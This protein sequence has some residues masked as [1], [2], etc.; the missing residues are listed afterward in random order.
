MVVYQW[1]NMKKDILTQ[2]GLFERLVRVETKLDFLAE[3]NSKT[4]IKFTRFVLFVIF[5]EFVN[6]ILNYILISE[7]DK[8]EVLVKTFI[9]I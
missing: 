4:S 9:K 6:L 7:H 8:L 1:D 3:T 2:K 5:I